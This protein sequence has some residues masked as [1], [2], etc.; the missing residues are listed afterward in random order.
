MAPADASGQCTGHAVARLDSLCAVVVEQFGD[1]AANLALDELLLR[2]VSGASAATQTYLRFYGW[3]TPTLSLGRAQQASRVVD[4]G[5]C[6]RHGIAVARRPSGGK[7]VL[8]HREVTYALISNDRS[9]FPA[10]SIEESY[11]KISRALQQGLELLGIATTL[12]GSGSGQR[13]NPR[14]NRSH[15][16]FASAF[17]HEILSAGKKLAGSAQRRTLRG[18]LQHG[19]ILL[20]FDLRLLQGALLGHTP[21]DLTSNIATL[22]SCLG[23]PPEF[24][25]VVSCLLEGFRQVLRVPVE[26]QP[27]NPAIRSEAEALGRTLRVCATDSTLGRSCHSNDSRDG[28]RGKPGGTI[29]SKG[30]E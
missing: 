12:A 14:V 21:S 25:A 18:F 10:W 15:A 4:F 7:A 3:A 22:K 13:R 29:A 27:L 5:Y 8:H 6:R 23:K 26:P 2:R 24:A 11:R 16:C 19:S 9:L 1:G 30:E 28:S 17:H 20:D